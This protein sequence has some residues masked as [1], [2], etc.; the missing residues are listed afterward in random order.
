MKILLYVFFTGMSRAHKKKNYHNH[1][2]QFYFIVQDFRFRT[3]RDIGLSES[4]SD[5][6]QIFPHFEEK[7]KE[8]FGNHEEEPAKAVTLI[9]TNYTEITQV[10]NFALI[11]D[12]A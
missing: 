5:L 11:L 6:L 12:S 2:I 4:I 3:P 10:L 7:I 8:H 9:W 1:Y